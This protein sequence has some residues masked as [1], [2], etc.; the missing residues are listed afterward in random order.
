MEAAAR[1]A[2]LFGRSNG[3]VIAMIHVKALPGTP[4]STLPMADI[5]AE[6]RREAE[7]YKAV[8]VDAVLVE[9]MGD[10]PYVAGCPGPEVTAAMTAVCCSLRRALPHHPLGVQVL[11]G[12]N[13]QALAVALAA[14]LDFVRVEGFVFAHVAD[15]GLCQAAAGPLLRER[16]RLGADRIL[17]LADIKKKHSAHA[18]TADVGVVDTALA[19]QF[20]LA[21]GVVLTGRATACATSATQLAEVRAAVALPVLVGSGVTLANVGDYRGASGLIV[22]SHLKRGGAWHAEL[23]PQRAGDFMDAVRAVRGAGGGAGGAGGAGAGGG[24]GAGGT[25]GALEAVEALAAEALEALAEALEAL[26]AV[27]AVEALAEALAEA[28][29]VTRRGTI[30]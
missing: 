27:E 14:G 13:H 23:S 12:A 1:F 21:D 6:A 20:F 16:R 28:L 8:G 11:A 22:G 19:A 25:G 5:I 4:R 2:S 9:N 24:G 17:L 3:V 26:E 18:V 15:E 10:V 29:E 30:R 7:I